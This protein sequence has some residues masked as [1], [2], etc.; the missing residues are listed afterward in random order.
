M[1]KSLKRKLNQWMRTERIDIDK[2]IYK[3]NARKINCSEN[4]D[5]ITGQPSEKS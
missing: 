5:G 1:F 3:I 2:S 4:D